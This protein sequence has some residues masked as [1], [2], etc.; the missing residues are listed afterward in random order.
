MITG[1]SEGTC[2]TAESSDPKVARKP[3]TSH[4]VDTHKGLA[5]CYT[6]CLAAPSAIRCAK[7]SEVPVLDPYRT[8]SGRAFSETVFGI[9]FWGFPAFAEKLGADG[10]AMNRRWSE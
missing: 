8:Y 10:A 6:P 2:A 4:S 7:R 9:A 5:I 3:T 1:P